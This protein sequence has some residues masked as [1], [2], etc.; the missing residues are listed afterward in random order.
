MAFPGCQVLVLKNGKEIYNKS[1]GKYTYE[2][3]RIVTPATIYDLASLSKTTGT[4]LAV[5]KLF[6]DNKL[7]INDKASDYLD[8]LKGTNKE[9]IK[10]VDLLFHETGLP[11]YIYFPT[12]T[13]QKN[14]SYSTTDSIHAAAMK[15]IANTRL[16]SKTYLYSCINFVLLKEIVETISGVTLDFFLQREF[17]G[18]MN[19]RNLGYVPLRTHVQDE[20]APT[21]KKISSNGFLQGE[22]HDPIA[23]FFGGVSGNAGLFGTA[24]DVAVIYQM[25][26]N[27]GDLDGK[28]YLCKRTCQLFTTT[29]SASGRRGL[30]FDKP[31]PT[32]PAINPCSK[33]APKEVFGHTGYTGTCC[34]VDPVNQLV[35]VFLSNRTYPNDGVNKL[36]RMSIRPK[37]QDAIYQSIINFK[38]K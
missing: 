34:W 1:F 21:L 33:L 17:Y 6:D 31:V 37:I 8:F 13:T 2:T 23:N 3:D 18:P 4:L 38:V 20:I 32:N 29:V 5:M 36:A 35:Y 19:L 24:H 9:H 25:M 14:A 28:Q 7:D 12:S 27:N 30:G 15:L 26:L 10:I 11:A 22:V 16:G